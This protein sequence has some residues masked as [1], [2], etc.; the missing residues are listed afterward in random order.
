MSKPALSLYRSLLRAVKQLPRTSHQYYSTILRQNFA[1]FREETDPERLAALF[2]R[3]HTDS[4]WI[5]KKFAN[6]AKNNN[7]VTPRQQ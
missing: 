2:V 3:A 1:T 6:G 5:I 4:A 7:F